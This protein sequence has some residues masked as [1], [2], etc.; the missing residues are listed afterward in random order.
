MDLGLTGKIALVTG[1]SGG[2]GAATAMALAAEG[3][4]VAIAARRPEALNAVAQKIEAA[5]GTVLPILW[6]L[7]DPG[8]T[9]TAIAEIVEKLGSVDILVANTG[10]PP[11]GPALGVSS[12]VWRQQF[13]AMVLSVIGI[14][15]QLVPAMRAK[16]W[17]RVVTLASSGVLAPIANLALSNALRLSLVG[18]SKTLAAEV[19]ADGVTVNVVAPGRIDT[20][21][22]RALDTARAN[23][24]GRAVE[25]V[26]A[27]SRRTIPVGRY[28]QPEEFA[29]VVAFLASMQASYV[30]GSVI[31]VDG[32]M[33][34]GL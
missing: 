3:A 32:G 2:L 24:E 19:A 25:E 13:E 4:S 16:G 20:D 31:R 12:D 5:G 15:D 10:G 27:A 18:W 7:S 11:P 28:G 26:A 34:G 1:A 30:T 6:D 23:R 29:A 9:A 21:R 8:R 17:G 33:I 22:V 14:A